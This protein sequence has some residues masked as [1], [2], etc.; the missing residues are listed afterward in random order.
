[1]YF[2][3][4]EKIRSSNNDTNIPNE[5]ERWKRKTKQQ[6]ENKIEVLLRTLAEK[7]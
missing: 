5:S 4:R 3:S 6:N 2:N 1:M 7:W